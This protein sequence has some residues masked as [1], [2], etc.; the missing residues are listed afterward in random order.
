MGQLTMHACSRWIWDPLARLGIDSQEFWAAYCS[1][2]ANPTEGIGHI[3]KA[4]RNS[5]WQRWVEQ[6]WAVQAEALAG[7][8]F[9]IDLPA[10]AQLPPHTLGGA[11]ARH[12]LSSG[13]DPETFISPEEDPTDWVGRRASLAHDV[14]HVILGWDASPVGE[15]GVAAFCLVQFWDLLNVFVLS[16][17]PLTLLGYPRRAPKLLA[18]LA[19]GAWLGLRSKPIFAYPFEECWH[20]SLEEVRKELGLI[21]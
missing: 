8:V 13:F 3:L 2:L 11:Y 1:F 7:K 18:A 10:L 12:M 6:R 20:V 14:H 5:P 21:K 9:H 4:G 16:F 19:R 17:V 15:M